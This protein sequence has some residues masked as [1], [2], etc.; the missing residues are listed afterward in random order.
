MSDKLNLDD[1]TLNNFLAE[2]QHESDRAAAIV[3][4]AQLDAMLRDLIA[5]FLIDE[6]T[7]VDDLLGTDNKSEVPLSSFAARIR[8]AYCLGLISKSCYQDL[9][10]VKKIRNKFAHKLPGYSFTSPE[11]VSLC[12]S[13]HIPKQLPEPLKHINMCSSCRNKYELV[14]V[15]IMMELFHLI[16]EPRYQHRTIPIEPE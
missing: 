11:I 6:P 2:L 16:K 10:L 3:S 5:S 13:F 12:N 9:M 8:A 14:V 15:M 4:G 7:V 1:V